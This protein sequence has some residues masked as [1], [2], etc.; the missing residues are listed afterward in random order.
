MV[1]NDRSAL[2]RI[3]RELLDR[4]EGADLLIGIPCFNNGGTVGAVV[5]NAATGL[6]EF[7]PD[8]RGCI[9]VAD[10]GSTVDDSRE[11]ALAAFRRSAELCPGHLV[12]RLNLAFALLRAGR[13]DEGAAALEAIL[14][15]DPRDPVARARLEELRA[16]RVADKRGHAPRP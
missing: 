15:L 9:V 10:G 5:E 13:D 12:P 7:F 11:E 6:R 14:E 2:R 3:T 4:I 8:Q 1:M 16:V